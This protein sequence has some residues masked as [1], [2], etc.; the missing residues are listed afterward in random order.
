MYRLMDK[1][2]CKGRTVCVDIDMT[3]TKKTVW[4]RGEPLPE[5]NM[6]VI[7]LINQMSEAGARII[8]FT[9]RGLWLAEDTFRWMYS[10]CLLYPLAL[11]LKPPADMYLD[12]RAC[13]PFYT[14]YYC[15]FV[16]E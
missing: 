3:L 12:D 11:G 14:E 7:D 1:E 10:N 8:L 9:A 2:W 13:N 5:P 15:P 16:R 6:E 4:S